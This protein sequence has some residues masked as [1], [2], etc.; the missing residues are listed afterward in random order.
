MKEKLLLAVVPECVGCVCEVPHK[1]GKQQM[2]YDTTLI[3]ISDYLAFFLALSGEQNR[4]TDR[5]I[6]KRFDCVRACI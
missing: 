2:L 1:P 3:V 6:Y 4:L 5:D